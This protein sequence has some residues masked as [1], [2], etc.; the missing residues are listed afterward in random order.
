MPY[1]NDL[2]LR[3]QEILLDGQ[4]IANTNYQQALSDVDLNIALTK[5][6]D[7][8]TIALLTFHIN[9]YI[10]GVVE[11]FETEQLTIR[12]KFSF[13]MPTIESES[14]WQQMK[15]TLFENSRSLIAHVRNLSNEQLDADF[16]DER[17]GSYRRNIDGMIEH[18][19][20]H[21]GQIVLIK[22]LIMD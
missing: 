14:Q 17:Y 21:L 9:Y 13:D 8:N 5:V 15:S 4:W 2:S 16:F 1:A 18:C 20:Y 7:L 11:A 12:D 3:L 19:Y 22:K 10:A 6:K